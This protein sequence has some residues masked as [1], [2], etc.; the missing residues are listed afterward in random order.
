MCHTAPCFPLPVEK[1]G[2][3][4]KLSTS[5]R[6]VLILAVTQ[7]IQQ[8]LAQMWLGSAEEKAPGHL[9]RRRI[10][11]WTPKPKAWLKA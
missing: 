9:L 11:Q 4:C 3:Q 5:P 8:N 7:G 10:K 2:E 1:R 6:K